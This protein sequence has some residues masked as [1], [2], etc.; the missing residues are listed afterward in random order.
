M[1]MLEQEKARSRRD[2]ENAEEILNHEFLGLDGWVSWRSSSLAHL[3]VCKTNPS[4]CPL[5]THAKRLATICTDLQGEG[6]RK[7]G[8]AFV[9][10]HRN[11][12]S[13][14]KSV[15]AFLGAQL[16]SLLPLR[17]CA[18]RQQGA[19]STGQNALFPLG[20][21]ASSSNLGGYNAI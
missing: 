5:P 12:V 8:E 14:V 10:S 16:G 20:L 21:P 2:A 1:M 4:P 15:V 13:P 11:V 18:G 9:G 19:D 3:C 6:S 7:P 17:L